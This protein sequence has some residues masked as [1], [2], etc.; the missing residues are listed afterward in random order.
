MVI[1]II[2]VI[3]VVIL[4]VIVIVI[5]IVGGCIAMLK[6]AKGSKQG[7]CASSSS[8]GRVSLGDLKRAS[9]RLLRRTNSK[10]KHTPTAPA[11]APAPAPATASPAS[12][13]LTRQRSPPPPQVPPRCSSRNGLAS[14][15]VAGAVIK[16]ATVRRMS[17]LRRRNVILCFHLFII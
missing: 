10:A 1:V 16:Q 5:V 6:W 9:Q 11:P 7:S 2:I 8:A 17:T 4:I 14:S 13:A 15:G 3:V 12:P